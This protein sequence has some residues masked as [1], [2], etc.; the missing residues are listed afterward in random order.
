ML[1]RRLMNVLAQSALAGLVCSAA[2][3]ETPVPRAPPSPTVSKPPPAAIGCVISEPPVSFTGD[4][5]PYGKRLRIDEPVPVDSDKQSEVPAL[6]AALA[7]DAAYQKLFT[8]PRASLNEFLSYVSEMV[9]S[10]Q[11]GKPKSIRYPYQHSGKYSDRSELIKTLKDKKL[12]DSAVK[13]Y[14]I[15]ARLGNLPEDFAKR[16]CA[17]LTATQNEPNLGTWTSYKPGGPIHDYSALAAWSCPRNP[18]YLRAFIDAKPHEYNLNFPDGSGRTEVRDEP[19]GPFPWSNFLG[20]IAR[21]PGPLG[22]ARHWLLTKSS[23]ID[24]LRGLTTLTPEEVEYDRGVY[25]GP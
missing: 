14:L 21:P 6:D 7:Q 9:A 18:A 4:P 11:I 22:P 16:L 15:F 17:H 10:N 8:G 23:A 19:T 2:A 3:A 12:E 25:R 1:V 24:R 5:V 13:V 20:S